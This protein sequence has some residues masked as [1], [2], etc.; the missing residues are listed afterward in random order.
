MIRMSPEIAPRAFIEFIMID[1]LRHIEEIVRAAVRGAVGDIPESLDLA[2]R[3]S[4]HADYQADLALSLAKKLERSPRDLANAIANNITVGELLSEVSV[5]GPGFI[6]L[7]L[8]REYLASAVEKMS[9]DPALGVTRAV[10]PEV[11]V[12]DYSS[13]NLA[14][15]MHVGH[16]RSTIIG[17]CLARVLQHLGHRVIRQNHIGDW[18]TPFGMLIEYMRDS[19]IADDHGTLR[20]LSQFYRAAR[21]KFDSDPAFAERARQRVVMLQRGDPSTLA[22]W[23]RL[24]GITVG[25]L[26]K[27]Y[28][29]LA[30]QLGREHMAGE[31]RYNSQLEEVVADLERKG[32]ARLSDGAMCVFL[33]DFVGRDGEPIPLIVRKQ[34]GGFGYAATDLAALRYRTNE[35]GANRILYVVGAPQSQHFAMVFQ[36]ARLAGWIDERVRLDHVA[37]GSVLGTDGKPLKTRAGEAI[38]LAELLAEAVSRARAT[39]DQRSPSLDP[40]ERARIAEAV[41]IGA[42]KY[43]DLAND[44]VRDYV[45]S[46]DRMLALEGN[47][48]P[49]LM[50][51]HARINSILARTD[52]AAPAQA[53]QATV[54]IDSPAE[55]ALVLELLQFPTSLARVSVTLQP[56]RLCQQLFQIATAFSGF[57]DTCVVLK[58]PE[59]I[60]SSRLALCHVTARVLAQGLELLGIAAPQQM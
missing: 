40:D 6:N 50:Y 19:G 2:V 14:K 54:L 25:H 15:E 44:R 48:A 55:R 30:V 31:S 29:Q 21:V 1:P 23:Q 17:D 51:A 47:T 7:S 10:A 56:H 4:T 46:W 34:D 38:S 18:G 45:F 49:Y 12:I 42:V 39:V 13:P 8:S 24:I 9:A 60:R 37:F 33:P 52:R 27:L 58:A 36:T 16:L 32:L 41:G 22:L 53:L 26:E 57:Y 11:V 20:E 35:L 5:S 3:R 43:A 28:G 59:P